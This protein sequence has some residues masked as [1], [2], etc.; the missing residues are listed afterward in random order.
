M[1]EHVAGRGVSV[2][3]LVAIAFIALCVG[4]LAVLSMA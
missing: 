3:Y 1:G 2:A 4:A